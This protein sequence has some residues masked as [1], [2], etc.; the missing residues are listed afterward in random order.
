MSN[1]E[2]TTASKAAL[3]GLR[4]N[5]FALDPEVITIVDKAWLEAK[6]LKDHHLYDPRAE[7]PAQEELVLNIIQHGV[8]QPINVTKEGNEILCVEGRQR[9]KAA[10]EANRR[11]KAEGSE[12]LTIRCIAERGDEAELMGIM[13]LAN[14]LRYADT[15]L[16]KAMK[17]TRLLQ[18][19]NHDYKAVATTF[20]VSG[21]T[22]R[23]WEKLHNL[24][25]AAKRAVEQGKVSA[26]AAV[27]ELHGLPVQEQNEL[28]E[29][30]IAQAEKQ[31]KPVTKAQ[32]AEK[33]GKT[34]QVK[35]PTKDTLKRMVVYSTSLP[36]EAQILLQ[37]ITHEITEEEACD[38]LKWLGKAITEAERGDTDEASTS[39]TGS[40]KTKAPKQTAKAKAKSKAK[41]QQAVAA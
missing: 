39:S 5:M 3:P 6:G 20:G 36:A 33:T 11:L 16:H 24:S 29:K 17:A 34:T 38:Q 13:V 9:L 26:E 8:K 1:K 18:L 4:Q 22:I 14:E 19:K 40:T 41:A 10:Q 32:A 27:A 25:A 15:I 30:L 35:T 2:T 12:T 23:R 28:V 37:W 21:M 7:W 31:G